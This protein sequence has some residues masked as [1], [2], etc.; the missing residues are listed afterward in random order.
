MVVMM[1]SSETESDKCVYEVH[2]ATHSDLSEHISNTTTTATSSR[3][4][5]QKHDNCVEMLEGTRRGGA[6]I[7][8]C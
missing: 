1:V 4:L 2:I 8:I 6:T 5:I 3:G 7:P